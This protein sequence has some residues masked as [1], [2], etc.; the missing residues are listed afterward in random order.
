[1]TQELSIHNF[2]ANQNVAVHTARHL[3]GTLMMP[4]REKTDVDSEPF[5]IQSFTGVLKKP[6][7]TVDL[8]QSG[9]I[10]AEVLE[11]HHITSVEKPAWLKRALVCVILFGLWH[12][13]VR[14]AL[15]LDPMQPV[16]FDN[17]FN[18]MLP[19]ALAIL[20]IKYPDLSDKQSQLRKKI[21][22]ARLRSN[23]T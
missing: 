23:S 10:S 12:L 13:K 3:G 14:N 11:L 8:S 1:M 20:V 21:S 9:V 17:L 19:L 22:Q 6:I 7:A 15:G 4:I 5:S 18:A 16:L 2:F